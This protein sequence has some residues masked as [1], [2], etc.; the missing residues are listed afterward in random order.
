M[1]DENIGAIVVAEG[2]E[3]LGIVTDR[4]VALRVVAE[5]RAGAD[6]TLRSIM[7]RHPA[8]VFR[9]RTLVRVPALGASTLTRKR[10]SSNLRT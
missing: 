7:T 8:F 10:S 9:H 2:A 6:V 3:P 4:D 5:G 1:R